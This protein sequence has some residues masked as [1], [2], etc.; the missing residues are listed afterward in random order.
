MA[1]IFNPFQMAQQQFDRVADMLQLDESVREY[2]RWPQKEFHFRIPVRMDNGSVRLFQ[3]FRIQHNNA[4]GPYK[5]GVRFHPSET[6]D[7]IRALA[8]W[9]T[10][11]CA[12]ADIPLGG[13]KGGVVVDPAALS[14]GEKERLVRGWVQQMYKNI[15]PRQDVPAPDVGTNAQMM[16][17]MMDEF[18]Y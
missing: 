15:G 9:M 16:A 4:R 2:L 10:W 17:W 7:G 5:G 11:K 18:S 8:T 1:A 12:V 6:V 3:G 14:I 13:A